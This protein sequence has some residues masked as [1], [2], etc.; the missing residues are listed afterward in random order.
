MSGYAKVHG[1]IL[2][3]T[4]WVGQSKETRLTWLTMLIL[5]DAEGYVASSVPGLAKEAGVTLA[6]CEA[7]LEIFRS[8]D[9]YSRTKD[10]EGRR[11]VDAD[12]GWI[13]LN[14]HKYRDYKTLEQIKNAERQARFKAKKRA[15]RGVT[16]DVTNVSGNDGNVSAAGD[17]SGGKA[18]KSR[19]RQGKPLP[20]LAVT[21]VTGSH[22]L[23]PD[24]SLEEP[25][26]SDPIPVPS[27]PAKDGSARA[28]PLPS[29]VFDA[30]QGGGGGK[31]C[32]VPEWWQGPDERCRVYA[33]ENRLP[34]D[35]IEARFRVKHFQAPF[36]GTP[37]GVARR[38]MQWLIE[39]KNRR[40]T[41]THQRQQR[42][43]QVGGDA[44]LR[45][46]RMPTNG[47]AQLQPDEGRTGFEV[48]DA[49]MPP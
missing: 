26:Q 18:R 19:R 8:P 11:I 12:G 27:D 32:D 3:S 14:L 45:R 43:Q 29:G 31:V 39:E 5:A 48:L 21:T 1:S 42:Q 23:C 10:Y 17:A 28:T 30:P 36:P 47:V 40:D 24:Q 20:T 13:V 41:E 7:A 49:P 44:P 15:G 46:G 4:V 38:F 33:L 35:D 16:G 25:D 2:R 22:D 6:E 9:A 34:L 37:A